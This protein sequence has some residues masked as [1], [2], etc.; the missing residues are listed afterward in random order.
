MLKKIQ[1]PWLNKQLKYLQKKKPTTV[2]K[3]TKKPHLSL[4]RLSNNPKLTS[5]K[6]NQEKKSQTFFLKKQ[7]ISLKKR[8]KKPSKSRRIS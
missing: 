7:N 6:K 2:N 4:F 5:L 1:V 3:S 8:K